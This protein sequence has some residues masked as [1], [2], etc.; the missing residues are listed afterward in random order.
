MS[1]AIIV[2]GF[3]I[4]VHGG[5]ACLGAPRERSGYASAMAELHLID[6]TYELFRAWFA[7]PERTA[8]DG[9]EVGAVGG[10]CASMISLLNTGDVTHIGCAADHT[11][12]S[13]RNDLYD[14]YK[15][16]EGLDEELL[17]QFPIVEEGLRA[18]GMTVWPMVEFEA[19]D[20]MATAAHKYAGDFDKIWIG[21]PDKDL[22]QCVVGKEIVLWD[23]RREIVY[24]DAGLGSGSPCCA[25]HRLR[26]V[27]HERRPRMDRPSDRQ[28]AAWSA[29]AIAGFF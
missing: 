9:T 2:R 10:V 28:A 26:I 12:E 17:A 4:I 3:A 5:L 22:A 29:A 1:F 11:V 14:G 8:S 25:S 20:A 21:T 19:D 13:F 24:D 18:L 7:V 6:A 15:T 16:G 27:T 23:R